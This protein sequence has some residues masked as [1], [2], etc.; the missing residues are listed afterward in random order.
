MAV[1][2]R[3]ASKLSAFCFCVLRLVDVCCALK[4]PWRYEASAVRQVFSLIWFAIQRKNTNRWLLLAR[5]KGLDPERTNRSVFGLSSSAV[6]ESA[7]CSLLDCLELISLASA[8]NNF[9]SFTLHG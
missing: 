5:F 9:V 3:F 1:W 8:Q 6:S 2:L 7:Q 4:P